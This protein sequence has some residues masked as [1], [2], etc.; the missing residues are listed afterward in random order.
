M[1]FPKPVSIPLAQHFKLS[2]KDSLDT[3]EEKEQMR[4]IP[5]VNSIGCI[6][7][8]KVYIKLDLTHNTS[9]VSRFMSQLDKTH[10]EAIRWIL[11]YLK[12]TS[13]ERILFDRAQEDL[14]VKGYIDSNYTDELDMRRSLT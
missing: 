9:M 12:G 3:E 14:I 10:C 2:S 7:Y 4:Y 13:Y 5:Y 1:K 6:M 11:T 8:L